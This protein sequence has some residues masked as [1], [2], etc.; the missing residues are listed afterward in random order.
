[1][2]SPIL[3]L[4]LYL[5]TMLMLVMSLLLVTLM[6]LTPT[7]TGLDRVNSDWSIDISSVLYCSISISEKREQILSTSFK[8]IK[9]VCQNLV[10]LLLY[11]VK[12]TPTTVPP[13]ELRMTEK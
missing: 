10:L 2:I 7:S 3:F 5:V 6:T 8:K 4:P 13:M 11:F 12:G 9:I 1:M